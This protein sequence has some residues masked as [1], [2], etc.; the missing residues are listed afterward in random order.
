MKKLIIISAIFIFLY[1]LLLSY[2]VV[3]T[4]DDKTYTGTIIY[5]SDSSIIINTLEGK[6]TINRS[7]IKEVTNDNKKNEVLLPGNKEAPHDQ[8]ISEARA[9][10][11]FKITQEIQYT[12]QKMDQAT[13]LIYGSPI[14]AGLAE[15]ALAYI[16]KP[17]SPD[18][19]R[20]LYCVETGIAI[21]GVIVS[22][23]GL[24]QYWDG[25]NTVAQLR[26]KKYDFMFYPLLNT[27]RLANNTT[28]LIGLS[29]RL[30]I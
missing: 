28:G 1:S 5:N 23:V 15:G 9:D 2:D 11:L 7:Q 29:I 10:K 24:L 16:V 20:G 3:K 6:K 19:F 4:T 27:E 12:E 25:V 13:G 30:K 17:N 18:E 22:G 21:I 14:V 26:A 8:N